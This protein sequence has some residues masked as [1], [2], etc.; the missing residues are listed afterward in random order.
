[1]SSGCGSEENKQFV[2]NESGGCPS[3]D[4]YFSPIVID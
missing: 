4:Q 1:M 2:I 3:I